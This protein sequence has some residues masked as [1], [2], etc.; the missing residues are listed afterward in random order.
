MD[1]VAPPVVV[2]VTE[3]GVHTSTPNLACC[4][5]RTTDKCLL[6][7]LELSDAVVRVYSQQHV[8]AVE[9]LHGRPDGRFDVV[10]TGGAA[11]VVRSMSEVGETWLDLSHVIRQPGTIPCGG[12][13]IYGVIFVGIELPRAGWRWHRLLPGVDRYV[14]PLTRPLTS[15]RLAAEA[16]RLQAR[17]EAALHTVRRTPMVDGELVER[18]TAVAI[19]VKCATAVLGVAPGQAGEAQADDLGQGVL[20]HAAPAGAVVAQTANPA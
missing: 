7:P 17:I 6:T 14:V 16:F 13:L 10:A 12:A 9:E 5:L 11:R 15:K 20:L 1:A 8:V 4:C 2:T 19:G 18:A 3:R